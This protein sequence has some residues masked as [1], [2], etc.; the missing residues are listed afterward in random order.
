MSDVLDPVV[1]GYGLAAWMDANAR[2]LRQWMGCLV[3]EIHTLPQR[4]GM[5]V[6]LSSAVA[7]S[8]G[9]EPAE[10]LPLASSPSLGVVIP[11]EPE[12]AEEEKPKGP[13]ASQL[14]ALEL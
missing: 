13:P 8:T 11:F 3:P 6:D 9:Y 10:A 14:D 12:P 5:P 2:A 4:L 7:L 1:R